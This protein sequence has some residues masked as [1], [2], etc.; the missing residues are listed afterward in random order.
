[1]IIEVGNFTNGTFFML[2]VKNIPITEVRSLVLDTIGLFHV[3]QV[4]FSEYQGETAR[5]RGV[6]VLLPESATSGTGFGRTIAELTKMEE[7]L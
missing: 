7:L 1:M 3:N 2:K 4:S 6:R 5:D